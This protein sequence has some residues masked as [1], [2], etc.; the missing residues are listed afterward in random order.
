MWHWF[1]NPLSGRDHD[2]GGLNFLRLLTFH[3]TAV[4]SNNYYFFLDFPEPRR[5]KFSKFPLSL[6][7]SISIWLKLKLILALKGFDILTRH[8]NN[9]HDIL[10]FKTISKLLLYTDPNEAVLWRQR[11]IKSS[12]W[13]FRLSFPVLKRNVVMNDE[14]WGALTLRHYL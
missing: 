1:V 6:L 13:G 9:Q 2:A 10:Y 11:S 4:W 12:S 7:H 5:K 8:T 14:P 3:L